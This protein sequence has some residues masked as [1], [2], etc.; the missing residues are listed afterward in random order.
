MET[1][2]DKFK[3]KGQELKAELKAADE[4]KDYAPMPEEGPGPMPFGNDE[5]VMPAT[6]LVETQHHTD[7]AQVRH[8]QGIQG[9]E[10]MNRNDVPVPFIKLIHPG[11]KKAEL[12]D[13]SR[14]PLGTLF[15]TDT[16]EDLGKEIRFALIR[17]KHDSYESSRDQKMIPTIKIVGVR[18]NDS[19]GNGVFLPFVM[20]FTSKSFTPFKGMIGALKRR[21]ATRAWEYAVKMTVAYG[22]SENGEPVYYCEFALEET[23]QDETSL[24]FLDTAFGDF[25]GAI[26]TVEADE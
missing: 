9:L 13:G 7:L 19:E 26:D 3:K 16:K 2:Y 6:A 14:A 8:L 12:A 10:E 18:L 4:E 1:G 25:A 24:A 20:S 23:K 21:K 5:S 11:T 22:K 15:A 17:S